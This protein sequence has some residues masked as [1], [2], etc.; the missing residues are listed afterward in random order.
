MRCCFECVNCS[1]KFQGILEK[2][3]VWYD[4]VGW[5]YVVVLPS[6]IIFWNRGWALNISGIC[7]FRSAQWSFIEHSVMEYVV[8]VIGHWNTNSH[9]V[10]CGFFD[11][12]W[13]IH[14]ILK[15]YLI[16]EAHFHRRPPSQRF[17][18]VSCCLGEIAKSPG[19]CRI[20]G[21]FAARIALENVFWCH[22]GRPST[23]KCVSQGAVRHLAASSIKSIHKTADMYGIS[24]RKRREA[25]AVRRKSA[26]DQ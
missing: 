7:F 15:L 4:I 16:F 6:R 14:A 13:P 26:T 17:R 3:S 23:P 21:W 22:S 2:D 8:V 25:T 12:W 24:C 20:L 18:E 9:F 10:K 11:Y 19:N 1:D 5:I